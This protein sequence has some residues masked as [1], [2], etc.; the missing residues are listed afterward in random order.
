M[1]LHTVYHFSGCGFVVK[2]VSSFMLIFF[3]LE[4]NGVVTDCSVQ[5]LEPEEILEF[6]FISA[7]VCNKIIMKVR[8]SN[9]IMSHDYHMT[10]YMLV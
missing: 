9:D 5:T 8:W 1:C 4:E 6:D 7:N 3:S 10:F 2:L